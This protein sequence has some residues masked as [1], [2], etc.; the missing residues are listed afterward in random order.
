MTYSLQ[1]YNEGACYDVYLPSLHP[2]FTNFYF[3]Y[4]YLN[5]RDWHCGTLKRTAGQK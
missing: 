1:N 2:D 4:K 3:Y 5:N